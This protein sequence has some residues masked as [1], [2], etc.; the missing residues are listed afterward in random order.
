MLN[1]TD[2]ERIVENVLKELSINVT[3]SKWLQPDKIELRYK[4]EVISSTEFP[5]G[6]YE[7]K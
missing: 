2:V 7:Q 4:D 3:T 6:D 1:R 5:A